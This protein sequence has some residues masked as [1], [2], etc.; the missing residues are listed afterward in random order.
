ME[1]SILKSVK[2]ILG[3]NPNDTSFDLD[4][5]THVNSAFSTLNDLGIGPPE[6]F[7][8]DDDETLW[9]DFIGAD[10]RLNQVRTYVCLKTRIAF[11]PPTTVYLIGALDRQIAE[12]EWRLNTRRE[13]TEWVDPETGLV[14]VADIVEGGGAGG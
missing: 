2:K 6:G 8:I 12:L 1:Q 7:M 5:L 9:V 10:P 14:P 11:D 13:A 4:I 3:V